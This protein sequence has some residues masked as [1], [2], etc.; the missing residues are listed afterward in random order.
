MLTL[1]FFELEHE[2]RSKVKSPNRSK[3]IE[4]EFRMVN[5]KTNVTITDYIH[6]ENM[7]RITI[8]YGFL[9]YM[10]LHV[11]VVLHAQSTGYI[12]QSYLQAA[13]EIVVLKNENQIIPFKHLS[14]LHPLL[15]SDCTN[16]LLKWINKYVTIENKNFEQ[17]ENKAYSPEINI[18]VAQIDMDLNNVHTLT[19][20]SGIL[21]HRTLPYVL[22]LQHIKPASIPDKLFSRAKAILTS[23]RYNEFTCQI[24]AGILFG[25]EDCDSKLKFLL[26][27]HYKQGDGLPVKNLGRLRYAPSDIVGIGSENFNATMDLEV[28]DALA[29]GAFPGAN[30]LVV[31][32]NTVIFQKAYG[33]TTTEKAR[34]L[35]ENDLYDLASITKILS[36][37]SGAMWLQSHHLFDPAETVSTYL[38]SFRKSNKS[39]LIWRN[40]LTHKARL[41]ASITYYKNVI[42]P[43][44]EYLPR[45]IK[46]AYNRTYRVQIDDAWYANKKIPGK[47][48]KTIQKV[49]LLAKEGYVYSDLSM[50]LLGKTIEKITHQPLNQFVENNIYHKIRADHT[51]YLPLRSYTKDQV[52]PTEL[53]KTFRHHLIHGYVHDENAALLGGVSG[54]AGLFSNANDIAKLAQ[55]LLNKGKYGDEVLLDSNVVKEYTRYQSPETGNR[56]GLGFDKPLLEYNF[57]ASPVAKDASPE[58]F[59]H[60]GFTGTFLWIDPKYNL[61]Y[62]LL[63]NRVNPTRNNNKL[64]QLSI[65]PCIQ[66]SIYNFV[67]QSK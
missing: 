11:L 48:L 64:S 44:G 35:D 24:L 58:S 56:R 13:K 26:N 43:N 25:A 19:R 1:N 51:L 7:L 40:I 28:E 65:R 22:I 14:G 37:T 2:K 6:D 15:I 45:T 5:Y 34:K 61:I 29:K 59:G 46:P 55:M 62:I 32:D 52:V 20:L 50:I 66:Q 49:P 4:I 16:D 36:A 17:F 47:L 60:S 27:H 23:Q 42:S 53:D 12:C 3:K 67:L 38:P 18:L 54:H 39:N 41:P 30:L 31:K 57:E 10:S 9:T 8:Q 63:T 33:F 21:D